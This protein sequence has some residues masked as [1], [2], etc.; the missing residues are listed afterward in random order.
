[1]TCHN[2]WCD[3]T[4]AFNDAQ[5]DRRHDFGPLGGTSDNQVRTFRHLGLLLAPKPPPAQAA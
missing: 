3:Y 5:L 4:L 2:N 1:M